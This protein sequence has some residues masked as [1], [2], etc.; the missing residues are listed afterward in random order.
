MQTK[1]NKNYHL[2]GSAEKRWWIFGE[3]NYCGKS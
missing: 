1:W 2:C 3:K